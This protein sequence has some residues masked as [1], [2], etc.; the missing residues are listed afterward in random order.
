MRGVLIDFRRARASTWVPDL[1]IWISL[2]SR[3][4]ATDRNTDKVEW[5]CNL[6]QRDRLALP[7]IALSGRSPSSA[8]LSVCSE[9][10]RP[11]TGHVR[12]CKARM[13]SLIRWGVRLEEDLDARSEICKHSLDWRVLAHGSRSYPCASKH[14]QRCSTSNLLDP[15]LT[16]IRHVKCCV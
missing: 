5:I 16:I 2:H 6:F 11:R 12:T 10:A 1:R 8:R 15:V 14:E 13:R 7:R 9:Y 4:D 3:G